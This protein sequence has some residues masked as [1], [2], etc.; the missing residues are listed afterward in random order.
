MTASR[1]WIE[2]VILGFDPGPAPDCKS[3]LEYIGILL[4]YCQIGAYTSGTIPMTKRMREL[5]MAGLEPVG[6]VL[7]DGNDYRLCGRQ[8][9]SRR[10]QVRLAID[11]PR[12]FVEAGVSVRDM[13]ST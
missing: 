5:Q 13:R 11:A 8:S 2:G 4:V 7:R 3:G 12:I 9:N 10:F 6:A 1:K